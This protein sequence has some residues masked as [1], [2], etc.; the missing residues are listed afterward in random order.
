MQRKLSRWATEDKERK[1]TDLYS[2]LCNEIWLRVAHKNVNSNAGRETAGIDGTT[3]SDFNVNL[4]RHLEELKDDMK[5]RIFEPL[6]VVRAYVP[7]SNGK[8]RSLG[9]PGIKD[10]IV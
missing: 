9:I 1:F 4:D 3:M 7:K 8:L 10:R 6:P 5:A 2:L